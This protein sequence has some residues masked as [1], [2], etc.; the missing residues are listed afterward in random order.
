MNGLV[1]YM[2]VAV[3]AL[4]GAVG[5]YRYFTRTKVIQVET[6][7]APQPQQAPEQRVIPPHKKF[8]DRFQPK[9]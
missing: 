4:A 3:V 8:D 9:F 5:G 1:I 6:P 2:I 7:A